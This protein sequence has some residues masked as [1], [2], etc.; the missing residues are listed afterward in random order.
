MLA[1]TGATGFVGR[2]VCDQATRNGWTVRRIGR[3]AGPDLIGVGE[4]GPWTVWD[5]ALEGVDTVVHL[6]ARVHHMRER[7][8]DPL[9][10]YRLTN[11]DG[12]LHLAQR[13]QAMG[14]RRF[15]FVS[16]IK[17][18]GEETSE[19]RRFASDDAVRPQDAY[20]ISKYEAEQ[21]LKDLAAKTGLEVCIVRP[22]LVYGPDVGANFR[23]LISLVR[24]AVPLPLAR[25]QNK[26][27]LVAVGNLADLLCRCVEHP[28][29]AGQTFLCRDDREFSTPELLR[30]LGDALGVPVTLFPVPVSGLNVLASLSGQGERLRR[31]TESLQID[32]AHTRS[33]LGWTPPL[34]AE[35]AFAEAAVTWQSA[36]R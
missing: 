28:Q 31:L 25:I 11:V 21:G 19:G 29:A 14:V 33:L 16:S 30:A 20:G 7:A 3:M 36:M 9:P 27:S 13:A 12:T 1:V 8:A 35:A 2:A 5:Q 22:P 18:M 23:A 34:T 24:R 32:D 17:V 4:F 10:L 15:V 6:A 26:R